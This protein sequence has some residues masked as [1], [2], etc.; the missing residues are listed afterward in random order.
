MRI[1]AVVNQEVITQSDLNRAFL[2]VYLQMQSHYP[3]EQLAE[4]AKEIRERVLQQLVEERLMLQAALNPQP[5]EMGKGKIGI[6]MP[7]AVSPEEV[8]EMLAE[9]K[10]RFQSFEE[11][12]EALQE[13]G[14]TLEDLRARFKEQITIQKLIDREIRSKVSVSPTEVT[15]YYNARSQEFRELAAVQGAVILIKP[16]STLEVSQAMDLANHLRQQALQGTDFYDLAVRYSD[17]PNAK[18]GGRFGLLEKGKS[19]KEID[20]VLFSLKEGE[21]S[22]VVQTPAGFH[23]FRVESI[24]PERQASLQEVQD[25][26]HLRLLQE[27]AS[28]KYRDWINKLRADAYISVKP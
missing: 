7:I 15:A 18:M 5:I 20:Q 1:V 14:L 23:L 13:Q 19:R 2:P 12:E 28:V 6:P 11:M 24:R 22:P 4:K 17:G 21:I 3:P 9:T 16:K 26:I 10:A 25:E 8:E 27:K